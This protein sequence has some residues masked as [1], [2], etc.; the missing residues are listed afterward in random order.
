MQVNTSI[1][2][3]LNIL[4]LALNSELGLPNR[5]ILPLAYKFPNFFD[6]GADF[7]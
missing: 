4:Q 2:F 7:L 3:F 5:E 1:K 6:I